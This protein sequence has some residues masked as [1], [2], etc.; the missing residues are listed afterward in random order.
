M[1]ELGYEGSR[2]PGDSGWSCNPAAAVQTLTAE[3]QVC[4]C[5]RVKLVV[6]NQ[7][8]P[9]PMISNPSKVFAAVFTLFNICFH[10][11]FSYILLKE[12]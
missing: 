6:T 11:S 3:T 7:V 1:L 5:R 12:H 2:A 9:H 4:T 8:D 10:H